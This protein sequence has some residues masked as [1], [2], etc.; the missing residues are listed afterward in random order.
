[1]RAILEVVLAE[2]P[3]KFDVLD[4]RMFST[5]WVLARKGKAAEARGDV[6]TANKM[7]RRYCEAFMQY[8][9]RQ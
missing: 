4:A 3:S 1:M 9:G 5:L 7:W 8:S 2:K 6:E